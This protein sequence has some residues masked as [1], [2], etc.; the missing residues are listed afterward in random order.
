MPI[1]KQKS[2]YMVFEYYFFILCFLHE[3]NLLNVIIN[4]FCKKNK[5]IKYYKF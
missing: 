1:L 5:N 2:N 4:S 3:K